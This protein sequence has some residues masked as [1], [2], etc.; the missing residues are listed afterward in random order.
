[1]RSTKK[2]KVKTLFASYFK[3][4]VINDLVKKLSVR[5]PALRFLPKL[6]FEYR[7]LPS[8]FIEKITDIWQL[9]YFSSKP[10]TP[11]F[12]LSQLHEKMAFNITPST[13]D[14]DK[15]LGENPE[16]KLETFDIKKAL[17]TQS[18]MLHA[19]IQEQRV[20]LRRAMEVLYEEELRNIKTA[21]K[22][23]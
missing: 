17:E 12:D 19:L 7:F 3:Q 13:P 20:E 22:K 9:K 11:Y 4:Q 10:R 2:R 6:Y 23:A 1:M 16:L 21:K 18:D 15:W 14:L 8:A 5:M